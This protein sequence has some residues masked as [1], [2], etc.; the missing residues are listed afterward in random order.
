[1][2]ELENRSILAVDTEHEQLQTR[3]DRVDSALAKLA[4]VEGHPRKSTSDPDVMDQLR[5]ENKLL[6]RRLERMARYNEQ[7]QSDFQRAQ[8]RSS[9]GRPSSGGGITSAKAM[10]S[11]THRTALCEVPD[12]PEL[13][14]AIEDNEALLTDLRVELRDT[15]TA[16]A[17]LGTAARVDQHVPAHPQKSTGMIDVLTLG[18]RP[19]T[20]DVEWHKAK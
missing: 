14:K 3:L 17:R 10:S 13:S 12:D 1:M 2:L 11:R 7:L 8:L 15:A 20:S 16:V 19:G 9:Q 6:E 5:W 18:D 4:E